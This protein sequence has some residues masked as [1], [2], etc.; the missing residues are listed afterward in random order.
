MT[1]LR[2]ALLT[3]SLALLLAFS[4]SP[5]PTHAQQ[6]E[7]EIQIITTIPYD[8]PLHVFLDSLAS[9]FDRNPE[10][11]VR[12]SVNDETPMPYRTLR[13][14]LYADGV[15]LRSASHVLI[16][17]QFNLAA[18]GEGIIETLEDLYFIFRLD[19]SSEDLPILYLNAADPLVSS[20]LLNRGIPSTMNMKS[21]TPFRRYMAF[22][23]LH[24]QD[25][26]EVV[27]LGRQALRDD[28]APQQKHL[29]SL[30]NDQMG[31]GTGGYA[32]STTYQQKKAQRAGGGPLTQVAADSTLF[33]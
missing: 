5:A 33:E 21:Q 20:L 23:V 29:V 1:R 10:V 31:F 18:Q 19:E 25:R 28:M 32:L 22:P 15:D 12:R 13:D 17:Y 8:D 4:L 24:G 26:T 16:R 2:T 14:S 6:W 11:P 9:I 3:G 7:Q 27:E 30:L